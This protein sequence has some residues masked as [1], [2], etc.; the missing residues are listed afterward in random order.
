MYWETIGMFFSVGK[1]FSNALKNDWRSRII[2][3]E[4][5]AINQFSWY[6][7]WGIIKTRWFVCDPIMFKYFFFH[8]FWFYIP[9]FNP[10][11]IFLGPG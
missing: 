11:G 5:N 3:V 4:A 6:N 1:N 10:F 7:I 9:S 8:P 2:V